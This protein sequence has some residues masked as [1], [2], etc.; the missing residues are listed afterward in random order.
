MQSHLL[1]GLT[2]LL[3]STILASAVQLPDGSSITVKETVLMSLP[4]DTKDEV[5]DIIVSDDF[6]RCAAVMI[7]Q[8]MRG[9]L[10]ADGKKSPIYDVIISYFVGKHLCY[11]GINGEKNVLAVDGKI[12]PGCDMVWPNQDGSQIALL[13]KANGKSYVRVDGKAGPSFDRIEFIDWTVDGRLQYL[14][15]R[16]YEAT[17]LLDHEERATIPPQGPFY[18]PQIS[19]NG[20][21]IAYI[22]RVNDDEFMLVVD[23]QRFGP[24]GYEKIWGLFFSP[25]SKHY[26]A[27]IAQGEGDDT[28]YQFV[29]DGVMS[30]L[31]YDT[32]QAFVTTDPNNT[33]FFSPDSQHIAYAAETKPNCWVLVVDGKV[34]DTTYHRLWHP[35]FSPDSRHIG[36]IAEVIDGDAIQYCVLID[37]KE[38]RRFPHDI[39]GLSFSPD[40]RRWCVDLVIRHEDGAQDWSIITS[41]GIE[42]K[43]VE[44]S[45]DLF[46]PDSSHLVYL[47][48]NGEDYES[49]QYRVAV[50]IDGI[51]VSEE[52][53]GMLSELRSTDKGLLQ[54]VTMKTVTPDLGKPYQVVVRVDIIIEQPAR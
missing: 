17:Y 2:I 15:Y 4:S 43:N 5:H 31:Y 19:P 37:G 41:D 46:T 39:S 12:I 22:E 48:N 40:F 16:G 49:E 18:F 32:M 11:E 53:P 24:F 47:A 3:L 9:Y 36:G 28:K 13:M 26:I 7:R 52:Y 30:P 42:Y 35:I 38:Q 23:D 44:G 21:R 1:F 8:D 6:T 50:Y 33:H 45:S 10:F 29:I 51:K 34:S 25:D 54:V 27:E 14:G 20:K